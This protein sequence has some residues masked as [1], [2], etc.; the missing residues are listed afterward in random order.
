[1]NLKKNVL[2]LAAIVA[3][4]ASVSATALAE[5]SPWSI[6]TSVLSTD[7]DTA[8]TSSAPIAGVSRTLDIGTDTDTGFGISVGRTL[9]EQSLGRLR[10]EV[11]YTNTDLDIE[12]INFLGNDFSGDA[13]GGDV[14]VESIFARLVYQFE[15]G[16]IDPYVGI[17]I[18]STDV[19]VN[20][21]YG[22]SA[23]TTP[24][25]QPP[26]VTDNDSATSLEARIGAIY[27]VAD[28]VDLFL[29]YSRTEAD[30]INLERLG[31]GPGGLQTSIQEGDFDI[32]S[33]AFGVTYRF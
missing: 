23:G 18:G 11:A 5:D 9:F 24:G 6:S 1:M 31:G 13:V 29:E 10:A 14:E 28:N 25:A 7:L 19:D 26:F 12:N 2:N 21:V 32:D 8:E 27:S 30:D 33:I 22:G 3:I 17:G 20:A 16:K 4:S 15:L